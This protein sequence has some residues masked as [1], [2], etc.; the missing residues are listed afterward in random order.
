MTVALTEAFG[1]DVRTVLEGEDA[2]DLRRQ[3][4]ERRMG[5][6]QR[7]RVDAGLVAEGHQVP[8]RVQGEH[9]DG[10]R[11]GLQGLR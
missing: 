8:Q 9:R 1:A 10:H 5:I 4:A 11:G 2:R 3:R 7:G 6:G